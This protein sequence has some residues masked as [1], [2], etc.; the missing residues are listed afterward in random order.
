MTSSFFS[1]LLQFHAKNTACSVCLN[2]PGQISPW[3]AQGGRCTQCCRE[4][5]S[6]DRTPSTRERRWTRKQRITITVSWPLIVAVK[7]PPWALL[8]DLSREAAEEAEPEVHH[9]EGKVLVEEVAEETAHAQVGPAAVHQQEALQEAELGEGV[10][11]GQNSLDP[12]LTWD[13]NSDMSTWSGGVE[14]DGHR[15]KEREKYT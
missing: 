4:W 14:R 13:T 5:W 9:G 2:K 8:S 12:L 11:T 6:T 10:V 7:I 15:E 3:P 1:L